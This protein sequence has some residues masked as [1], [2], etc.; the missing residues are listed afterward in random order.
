MISNP[1]SKPDTSDYFTAKEI[2]T[3]R[4]LLKVTHCFSSL[5]FSLEEGGES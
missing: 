4:N 5:M 3:S 2:E 1:H